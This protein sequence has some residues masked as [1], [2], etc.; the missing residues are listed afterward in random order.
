MLPKIEKI[1]A[2][3]GKREEGQRTIFHEI[4]DGKLSEEEKLPMRLMGESHVF[5]GAGT[6]TTARNAAVTTFYLMK[7]RHIGDRLREE[8]RTVMPERDG[9]I[10]LAELEALPYLV[11]S[12]PSYSTFAFMLTNTVRSY[13]RRPT[14]RPRRLVPPATHRHPGGLDLQ[15]MDHPTRYTSH[16]ICLFATHGSERLSRTP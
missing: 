12:V 5:L 14:R 1:L 15:A 6:E 11:R 16:A 2:G 3:E 4:R 10:S 13:K 8:L 9:E 7:H